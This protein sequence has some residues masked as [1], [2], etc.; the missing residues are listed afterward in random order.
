[1][2]TGPVGWIDFLLSWEMCIERKEMLICERVT[3]S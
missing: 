1:M 2:N 3:C